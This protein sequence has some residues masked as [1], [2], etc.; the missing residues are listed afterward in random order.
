MNATYACAQQEMHTE[1]STVMAGGRVKLDVKR[2]IAIKLGA[3]ANLD[4]RETGAK[5]KV[6]LDIKISTTSESYQLNAL[7]MKT[8]S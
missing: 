3:S 5:T 1:K 8:I 4:M 2:I 6:L 7:H